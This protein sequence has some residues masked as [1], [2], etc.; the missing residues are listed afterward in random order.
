MDAQ[1]WCAVYS[2]PLLL[3][4]ILLYVRHRVVLYN[5]WCTNGT[6]I[7]SNRARFSLQNHST[8]GSTQAQNADFW[9]RKKWVALLP[10]SVRCKFKNCFGVQFRAHFRL[11][12]IY[13]HCSVV[14]FAFP[15]TAGSFSTLIRAAFYFLFFAQWIILFC[16]FSRRLCFKKQQTVFPIIV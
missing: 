12:I 15:L 6:P 13:Y 16:I 14:A 1:L 8:P 2:R 9:I 7:C 3:I 10:R 5:Y 11:S 4:G